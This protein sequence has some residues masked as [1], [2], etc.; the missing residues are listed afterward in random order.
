MLNSGPNDIWSYCPS[1]AAA[2]LFT[3]LFGITS[4][5]HIT[6]AFIYRKPFAWVLIMGALWETGGYVVRI[7]S[8]YHPL[9]SGIFTGQLLLILLA[10]L[11]VNAYIYML[12]GCMI[13]FFL[14]SDRV[15]KIKARLI[16][17][18]FVLF[19]ITAF[20][21]QAT[22]GTMTG[23]SSSTSTQNLGLDIYTAGVGVQ[24][25]FLVI[26]VSLAIGFQ[27]K[28]KKQSQSPNDI[29]STTRLAAYNGS[30]MRIPSPSPS[31]MPSM[32]DSALARPLLRTLYIVMTLII[33]RNLYRLVEFAMGANSP[34]VTHE[35][36]AYVFDAVP[37]FCAL[38]VLNVW[39]P[40]K[41]LQG[42]GSDFSAQDN[43]RK[44]AKKDKKV[45][46]KQEK[47]EKKEM[48]KMAKLGLGKGSTYT[49]V[50]N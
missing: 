8:I 36:F 42:P 12:L 44:Q 50:N 41:L 26:F 21:I 43:E 35:W 47:Q 5:A 37:M 6:Q 38:V 20:L 31:P 27:Q 7:L 39:N 3:I 32:P 13:H 45:T 4:T 18:M 10:P 2:I 19:D 34:T 24:L 30:P 16:T 33:L 28:L 17:R 29:E 23:P 14:E 48:K 46:K 40:G 49:P 9:N 25:G 1:L 15:F 22:G 11:W